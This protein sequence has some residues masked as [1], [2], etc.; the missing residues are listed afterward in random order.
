MY[1]L[2]AFFSFFLSFSFSVEL[3]SVKHLAQKVCFQFAMPTGLGEFLDV[4]E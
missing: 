3:L 1:P 2:P 4:E